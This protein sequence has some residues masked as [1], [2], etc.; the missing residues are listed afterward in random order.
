MNETANRALLPT[1]LR[2]VLPPDAAREAF[3]VDRL[4]SA[5][6]ANG[7]ERVKPPLIEFEEGLL[8]GAG[9]ATAKDTFRVM[10]PVSQR[11]MGLRADMTIQVARIATT[12]LIHAPRPLRLCYAGQVLRVKGSQLRPERQFTQA[13]IELIGSDS[14]AADAEVVA[15]TADAVRDLGVARVS[16]DLTLP[17][18]VPTLCDALDLSAERR[19]HLRAALDQK[20]AAAVKDLGGEIA[21]LFG[22]LLACV[23]DADS[24]LGRLERLSLPHPA[25]VLRQRLAAVVALVREAAPGIGLTVDAVENRGFEYQTGVSFSVFAGG[26]MTELGRGG[27][28]R[29]GTTREKAVGASLFIDAVTDVLPQPE[30]PP[31]LFV[32]QVERAEVTRLQAEG[33]VTV[34]AL[35]SVADA[36]AE[37]RRLQCS[38]FVSGGVVKPAQ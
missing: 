37:A 17:T 6:Q 15:L 24:V 13:G 4:L 21:A 31:R 3:A 20:D 27:R 36:A 23:G 30:A 18:L 34:A 16:A 14:P 5:F 22:D 35:D 2:D 11:M 12:R 32:P 9:A 29:A 19:E 25:D 7:Y 1:G 26:T 10:D 28:Y 8:D 38:H 33:W